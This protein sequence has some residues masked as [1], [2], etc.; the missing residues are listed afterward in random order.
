MTQATS[1]ARILT[2]LP[3]Q[4]RRSLAIPPPGGTLEEV[5]ATAV[6]HLAK[7]HKSEVDQAEETIEQYGLTIEVSRLRDRLARAATSDVERLVLSTP[8]VPEALFNKAVEKELEEEE[9]RES[10]SSRTSGKGGSGKPSNAGSAA[11]KRPASKAAAS[12]AR[13]S[14]GGNS[15]PGLAAPGE[16]Q[17]GER[18]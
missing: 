1:F 8:G 4:P 5:V 10:R 12:G 17:G 15:D 2:D 7:K 9:R 18:S 6:K 13:A 3:L 11:R 16:R 14:S